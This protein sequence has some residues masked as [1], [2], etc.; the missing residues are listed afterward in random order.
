MRG[1]R[2]VAVWLVLIAWSWLG[3]IGLVAI[4]GWWLT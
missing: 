1:V 3:V 2:R 4:I